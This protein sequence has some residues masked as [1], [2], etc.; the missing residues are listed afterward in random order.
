MA[1][2]RSKTFATSSLHTEDL[3]APLRGHTCY[4]LSFAVRADGTLASGSVDRTVRVWDVS[5]GECLQTLVGHTA[6]VC[7]LAVLPC[8]KLA[9]ASR[10]HT[11]RVW[12]VP[13]G[14][15]LRTLSGHTHW[16]V[17]LALTPQGLVSG[18]LDG[19][20]RFWDTSAGVCL[21]TVKRS[22]P[23]MAVLP[24]GKLAT[25]CAVSGVQVWRDDNRLLH[26]TRIFR[27]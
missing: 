16:V 5:N 4:V 1:P 18:S 21:R 15:C 7:A 23:F 8:E 11:V 19:T 3:R 6:G 2:F 24:D 10:D 9:S 25:G 26:L 20:M 27:F 22:A 13:S 17:S 14:A 12:D